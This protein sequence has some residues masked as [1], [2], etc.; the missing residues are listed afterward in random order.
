MH[1]G[2]LIRLKRKELGISQNDLAKKCGINR[3][4]IIKI[5]NGEPIRKKEWF[6]KIGREIKYSSEKLENIYQA[7][8]KE[9]KYINENFLSENSNKSRIINQENTK[10]ITSD[11][12]GRFLSDYF[13]ESSFY[14]R[15]DAKSDWV[16]AFINRTDNDYEIFK[17]YNSILSDYRNGRI[18][19]ERFQLAI[20]LLCL[21]LEDPKHNYSIKKINLSSY[22]IDSMLDDWKRRKNDKYLSNSDLIKFHVDTLGKVNK[23]YSKYLIDLVLDSTKM[24]WLSS[25]ALHLYE[26]GDIDAP[27]IDKMFEDEFEHF[28]SRI[29]R[30]YVATDFIMNILN[31]VSIYEIIEDVKISEYLEGK[32]PQD[33]FD[34][35]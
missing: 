2:N 7:Y 16:S 28:N 5:E 32:Q 4:S 11:L 21:T 30:M 29:E 24:Y 34:F 33:L 3:S 23:N 15:E 1:P 19:I 10:N 26:I 9:S 18:L 13:N 6:E 31:N 22:K 8:F 20:H 14:M 35:V 12:E 27:Q 17:G 25:N